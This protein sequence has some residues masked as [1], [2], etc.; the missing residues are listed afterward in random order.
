VAA[1][2]IVIAAVALTT[3][4]LR[5]DLGQ[6]PMWLS[7]GCSA[8]ELLVGVVLVGLALREAVPG[9][10]LPTGATTVAVV[11]GLGVQIFV[12][13]A[14][15]MHSPGL[16]LSSGSLAHGMGC[17][18]H[19]LVMALPTFVVALWLVF[20]ALPTRAPVAGMLGGAGAAITADAIIHLQC[21]MSDL[22][23]VLVWHTGAI[24]LFMLLG[25]GLGRMWDLRR[26]NEVNSRVGNQS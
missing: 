24:F 16:S 14:T 17:L 20:R 13:L 25:W 3:L 1:V 26:E 10:R 6:I 8:I 11:V 4:K 18:G 5:F 2:A 22:R 7:W 19:D 15:W 9:D 12:G 23:H 21:P